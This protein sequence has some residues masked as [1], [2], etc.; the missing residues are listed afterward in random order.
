LTEGV[1]KGNGTREHANY[2]TLPD[3]LFDVLPPEIQK[4]Y[5]ELAQMKKT[6]RSWETWEM[7]VKE[8]LKK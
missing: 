3:E 1:L 2:I 7:Q 4:K 8:F 5:Q 6:G